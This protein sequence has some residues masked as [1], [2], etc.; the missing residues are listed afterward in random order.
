MADDKQSDDVKHALYKHEQTHVKRYTC[1]T[2]VLV[3]AL[4]LCVAFLGGVAFLRDK[5][6]SR[7]SPQQQAELQTAHTEIIELP[8]DWHKPA[9]LMPEPIA[10][11]HDQFARDMESVTGKYRYFLHGTDRMDTTRSLIG[12]MSYD[13]PVLDADQQTSFALLMTELQPIIDET[14]RTVAMPDYTLAYDTDD[15]P[16]F[17]QIQQFAKLISIIAQVEADNGNAAGAMETLSLTPRLMKFEDPSYLITHLIAV[18]S[19]V[20]TCRRIEAIARQT[21]DT[22]ALRRGLEILNE[23]HPQ[24]YGF[25]PDLLRYADHVS[26]LRG[27][28]AHCCPVTLGPQTR[29]SLLYQ[30]HWMNSVNYFRWLANNLPSGDYRLPKVRSR[31]ASFAAPKAPTPAG[32]A[33]PSRF[34]EG[35]LATKDPLPR[36]HAGGMLRLINGLVGV[37]I[38]VSTFIMHGTN[39]EEAAIRMRVQ[40]ALYEVARLTLATRLVQLE[41]GTDAAQPANLEQS[42][43]KYISPIP[44]DPFSS[45]TRAM[46]MTPDGRFYSI[47]PDGK[48]DSL[49]LIYDSRRGTFS[50][51]DVYFTPPL[52]PSVKAP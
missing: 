49:S 35:L 45:G 51:G 9:Q 27:A 44:N 25:D 24:I 50:P 26:Y 4:L 6:L 30:Y 5:W 7:L 43:T 14:S 15:V 52:N 47:G 8:P 20:I 46:R 2:A 22:A 3:L 21:S 13:L 36:T 31:L 32:S 10:R 17:L 34:S 19:N 37:D 48:D 33:L 40:Q 29:A 1:I 28:A 16:N 11:F 38:L 42:V 12:R 18:A 41:L 23:V 39:Y